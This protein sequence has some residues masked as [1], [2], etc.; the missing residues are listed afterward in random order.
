MVRA[1]SRSAGPAI[2]AAAVLALGACASFDRASTGVASVVRPYKVDIVQGNFVSREQRQALKEGMSRV[3]VRDVLGTPLLSSVFHADRWDYVF[4]MKRQG[5]EPQARRLTVFFKN[6]RLASVEADA[7]PSED[8]FVASIDTR[9]NAVKVPVLQMTDEQLKA[10]ALP[11]RP[12]PAAPAL[13]PLPAT[14]PPLEPAS[15]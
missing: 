2:L 1:F 8:E 6:D 14:Y 3:E 11:A 15:R 10:T 12:E 7:L 5:V 4:T 13:P 9:T